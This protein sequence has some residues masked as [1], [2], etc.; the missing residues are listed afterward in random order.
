MDGISDLVK[1]LIPDPIEKILRGISH[2]SHCFREKQFKPYILKKNVEGV[3]F[4]FWIGDITGRQWYGT[5]D[6]NWPEM[7][8]IRDH[9][10]HPGDVILECGA[11]H[12]CLT[13]VLS[14]WVGDKGKVV[15]FEPVPK[16]A[17]IL[18][19]NIGEGVKRNN[20]RRDNT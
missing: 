14:N 20:F 8:F 4:D 17:D 12:G 7:R 11:H 19:K 15:A 2:C 18:Q 9:L 3:V 10:I 16:N 1:A 13:M 6:S 5:T